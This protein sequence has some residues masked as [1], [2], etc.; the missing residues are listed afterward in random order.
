MW[1]ALFVLSHT[2]ALNNGRTA[3]LRGSGPPVVFSSGLYGIC[4]HQA[5][6]SLGKL[7]SENLTMVHVEG[8]MKFMT[9]EDVENVADALQ[10][11][12]VG[13]FS[14]SSF[15]PDIL[16]SNRVRKAVL[17]DPI[18]VPRIS[19]LVQHKSLQPYVDTN[20]QVLEVRAEKLYNGKF[21]L[22]LLN[23]WNIQGDVKTIF[24]DSGHVDLMDDFWVWIAKKL[25]FWEMLS[26]PASSF[27]NFEFKSKNIKNIRKEYR[28]SLSDVS[29]A[30]FL[31]ETCKDGCKECADTSC[32]D[33]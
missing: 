17:C 22:P 24:M 14:H 18:G 20:V 4:P 28:K 32:L 6:N 10:V 23:Q 9:V 33:V 29:T 19:D 13:F 2:I 25:G 7:L 5:Y 21:E 12:Q 15:D 8:G 1:P 30:F 31:E 27:E 16:E 26:P 11:D 3:R